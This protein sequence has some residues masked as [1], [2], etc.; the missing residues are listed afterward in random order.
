MVIWLI[1]KS[2]SGKTFFAKKILSKIK[3]K[4]IHVDGDEIR[5]KFFKNKL[6][7]DIKSRRRNAE[8][9]VDLCKYLEVKGF[10]VVCSILNIFPEIQKKNR[11]IFDNYFQ[12]YL[13]TSTKI[14]KENNNKKV[15]SNKKN[16]VGID[17]NFPKPYKSDLII[18]NKFD[19][20][21]IKQLKKI[22]SKL[23]YF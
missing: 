17:I 7:F 18:Y 6:G 19:K 3:K 21:H 5:E 22:F 1:G 9:I 10:L 14:L 20:D 4:K 13:K 11:K 12:I 8:F 2:G 23:K 16:I 15:Y